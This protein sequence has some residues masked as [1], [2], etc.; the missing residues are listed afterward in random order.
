MVDRRQ[1]GRIMTALHEVCW[2]PCLVEVRLTEA[3][4]TLRRLPERSENRYRSTWPP[5][6]GGC[7]KANALRRKSTRSSPPAA[8][9]IDR[10][11]AALAWLGCL[12][13][14]DQQIVWRRASG[15]PWK[16]IS[17]EQTIDRTTAWRHWTSAL[18]GIA[19]RL[20]AGQ[21]STRRAVGRAPIAARPRKSS[22]ATLFYATNRRV[23]GIV[24]S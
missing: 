23:S 11:D 20:N 22:N 15:C 17:R 1:M 19:A 12:D 10:M 24:Q 2:T 6:Y 5:I 14:R 13:R 18:I 4:D 3:A 21:L 16:T 7:C 9:A 8:A